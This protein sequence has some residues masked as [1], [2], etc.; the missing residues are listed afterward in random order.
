MV[1]GKVLE[2]CDDPIDPSRV[3]VQ[4]YD[5]PYSKIE[6]CAIYVL[7]NPDSQRIEIGDRVWWQERYAY[8][9]P[10]DA[11]T[12]DEYG[13]QGIDFDIKILRFG[14]SGVPHPLQAP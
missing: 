10:Q 5:R 14:S 6:T 2:V 9:T 13:M 11:R 12:V 8:W 7:K 4:V 3:Y 1:G